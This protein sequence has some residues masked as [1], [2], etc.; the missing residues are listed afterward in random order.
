MPVC[1]AGGAKVALI[2]ADLFSVAWT[3]EATGAEWRRGYHVAPGAIVSAELRARATAPD[4]E[5]PLP[6]ATRDGEWFV[7]RGTRRAFPVV[8]F[9]SEAGTRDWKVCTEEGCRSLADLTG[10]APGRDITAVPCRAED[11]GGVGK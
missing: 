7:W 5:P 3:V 10:A 4:A 2:A 6:G 1:L 11:A 9:G 8:S